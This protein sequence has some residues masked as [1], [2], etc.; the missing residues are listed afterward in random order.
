MCFLPSE[1]TVSRKKKKM[2]FVLSDNPVRRISKVNYLVLLTWVSPRA[3]PARLGD[4]L[5]DTDI[6]CFVSRCLFQARRSSLLTGLERKVGMKPSRNSHQYVFPRYRAR[7][8]DD[9]VLMHLS[10]ERPLAPRCGRHIRALAPKEEGL[11]ESCTGG[12]VQ[13]HRVWHPISPL[14]PP[15]CSPHRTRDFPRRDCSGAGEKTLTK[16]RA[17]SRDGK[18]VEKVYIVEHGV[19][20]IST[21]SQKHHWG[22]TC[23]MVMVM[24]L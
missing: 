4:N 14:G 1:S 8:Q 12:R 9:H 10:F 13:R 11:S 6:D 2:R 18:P 19:S 24:W 22:T 15:P 21:H 16:C 3:A 23:M 20:S 5:E 17:R 7:Q